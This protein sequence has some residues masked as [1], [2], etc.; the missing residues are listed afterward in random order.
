MEQK[1]RTGS[2]RALPS[3]LKAHGRFERCWPHGA[4]AQCHF[5][6]YSL[7]LLGTVQRTRLGAKGGGAAR[8]HGRTEL[9]RQPAAIQLPTRHF[10]IQLGAERVGPIPRSHGRSTS[11]CHFEAHGAAIRRRQCD[12]PTRRAVVQYSFD[13]LGSVEES[14]HGGAECGASP[15]AHEQG[16]PSRECASS[17]KHDQLQYHH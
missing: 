5:V 6:Q 8:A 2:P 9:W 14:R 12:V 15:C 3:Y 4:A 7:G 10:I 16:L 13:G 11:R 1:R 17:T